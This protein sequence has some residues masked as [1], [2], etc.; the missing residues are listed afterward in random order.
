MEAQERQ[1]LHPL[2]AAAAVVVILACGIAAAALLGWLPAS[3]GQ[4]TDKAA[5]QTPVNPAVQPGASSSPA[6]VSRRSE[7]VRVA[8]SAPGVATAVARC[9]ECG[10]IESVRE[11]ERKGEGTGLGAV[12]G[13]VVGGIVGHQLGGGRGK[14]LMTVVGAVG[15][16]LA[17]NQ[18]EKN[19]RSA[20]AFEITVRLDDG[21]TRVVIEP[22]PPSWRQGDRVRFINGQIHSNA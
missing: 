10:V 16:G 13:A 9:A 8:K 7:T 18:I 22:N 4:P 3:T 12:G 19:V 15:G 1:A 14:D 21:S 20:R 2:F 6:T 5:Q 11:I 17:G